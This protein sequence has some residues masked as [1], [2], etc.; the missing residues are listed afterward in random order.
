[1][2]I[3]KT[4]FKQHGVQKITIDFVVVHQGEIIALEVKSGRRG[5]NS[6]LPLFCQKFNPRRAFV[7]G[8]DGVPLE[9]FFKMRIED[10]F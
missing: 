6:G 9:D 3:L 2:N 7:I 5:M 8:T 1:M 4:V 10:L